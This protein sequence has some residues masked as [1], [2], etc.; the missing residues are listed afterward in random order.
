MD[1]T[2]IFVI[3]RGP[4]ARCA[5]GWFIHSSRVKYGTVYSDSRSQWPRGQRRR[6]AAARL[7]RMWVR[8]PPGTWSASVVSVVC[9]VR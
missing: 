3:T 2:R 6:S 5:D 8:I 7:L 9:V 1:K 4:I